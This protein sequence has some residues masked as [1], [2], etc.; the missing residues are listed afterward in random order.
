MGCGLGWE[1]NTAFLRCGAT[2]LERKAVEYNDGV[3]DAWGD[4]GGDTSGGREGV[5]LLTVGGVESELGLNKL[6]MVLVFTSSATAVPRCKLGIP[7]KCESHLL[8]SW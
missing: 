8:L 6:P 5:G 2:R 1:G 4:G 3:G 7:T